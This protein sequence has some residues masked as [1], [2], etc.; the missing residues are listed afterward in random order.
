M[1]RTR[2]KKAIL[3]NLLLLIWLIYESV[4]KGICIADGIGYDSGTIQFILSC[5]TGTGIG[6]GIVETIRPSGGSEAIGNDDD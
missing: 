5:I 3:V 1:K 4:L 6:Y 2:L